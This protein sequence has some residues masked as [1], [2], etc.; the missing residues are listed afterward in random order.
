MQDVWPIVTSVLGVFLI[1][2]LGAFCRS[3]NWL[4]RE[5]DQSLAKLCAYILL[6]AYFI[7]RIL[8]DQQF[9]SLTVVWSPPLIGFVATATGFAV[10]ILFAKSCGPRIGLDTD[11]KRRA[12]ALCVGI[13]NY[14]Y[15]PYPIAEQFYPGAVTEL[16]LHNVGV[17]LALWSLGVAILNGAP[18][19]GRLRAIINPP[20][21]AVVIALTLRFSGAE[22]SLP[23]F[24][25]ALIGLVGSCAVPMG[26]ILSGAIIVDFLRESTWSGSVPIILSAI[27]IRQFLMPMLM[28]GAAGL[29][30]QTR[31]MQQVMVLQAAM[32]SAVFPIIIT[33]LYD[34]DVQTGLRVVLST[35]LAGIVLIPAWLAVGKWW[36]GA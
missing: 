14:G 10:G 23:K 34:K 9:D 3:V 21:I 12:F 26:L 30:I 35:S 36:L 25:I 29:L 8:E 4:S 33:R 22:A 27:G 32:P 28:L 6:P 17:E 13:C 15:I 7:D 18:G 16:I 20:L 24:A 5:A 31:D 2:G 1:V 11:A 19:A